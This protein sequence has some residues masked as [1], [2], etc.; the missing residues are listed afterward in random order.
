MDLPVKKLK[1]DIFIDAIS[2]H[3]PLAEGNYLSTQATLFENMFSPSRK[4][5]GREDYEFTNN[6]QNSPDET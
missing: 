5:V 4:G 3:H 1:V 2:Y 6:S